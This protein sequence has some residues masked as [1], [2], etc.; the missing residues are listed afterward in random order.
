MGCLTV[1]LNA[2]RMWCTVIKLDGYWV[3]D[4]WYAFHDGAYHAFY[5]KAPTS[6]GDPDLRHS[7][8]RIGHSV[9]LDLF[10]WTELPDALGAG[11]DGDFDDLAVWTGSVVQDASGWHLFYTGVET[12]SRTRIQR[13]GHAVSADLVSWERVST[14]PI[15][16]ADARWYST[17]AEPPEFDEPWRDPWVFRADDDLWHML[18]TARDPRGAGTAHGSIGHC[19]SVDLLHWE[20]LA[21]LGSR[22][23][24][25]QTEVLQVI[26]VAGRHVLILCA[27][28]SDLITGGIDARS[29]TYAVPADGPL[30][31]FHFDL[32]EPIAAAGIYA[33]RV[34]RDPTGEPVLLGFVL[35]DAD[36][37]FGGVIC[38]PIP[39]AL[40]DRGT[41]QPI[42]GTR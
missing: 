23:G 39:L 12:R 35:A 42:P 27:D 26:E 19:V 17:A 29:G 41:L 30:G 36:G 24:F 9:S 2:S 13:I 5:L 10:Q 38:D 7:S 31:P 25:R 16:T 6:L 21:P 22:S 20:V 37:S 40:T 14:E 8:A 33:G 4:S 32:A 34:L 11:A 3:W 1:P 15:V 18:V 28:A